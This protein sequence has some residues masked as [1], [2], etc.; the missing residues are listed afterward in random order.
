MDKGTC[1]E[2]P[3][4]QNLKINLMYQKPRNAEELAKVIADL[5]LKAISQV[6][7]IEISAA[8]F[9]IQMKPINLLKSFLQPVSNGFIG[10]WAGKAL[11]GYKKLLHRSPDVKKP[12]VISKY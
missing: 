7:D 2:R 1:C 4:Q 9:K 3:Y 5:E 8:L 10:K 12:L 11:L 6:E